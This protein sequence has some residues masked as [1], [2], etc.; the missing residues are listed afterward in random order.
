MLEHET[1]SSSGFS[2]MKNHISADDSK[3]RFIIALMGRETIYVIT[4]KIG[5]TCLV[6]CID[7]II[8][9]QI[10]ANYYLI[11]E[12]KNGRNVTKFA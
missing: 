3:R 6:F 11:A 9:H 7:L 4:L 8:R 2:E 10:Y 12:N 1:P 5:S